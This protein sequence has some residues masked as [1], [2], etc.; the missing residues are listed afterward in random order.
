MHVTRTHR[1]LG[2]TTELERTVEADIRAELESHLDLVAEELIEQGYAPER[3]RE[4][5][6]ERFGDVER[7][8]R[9]CRKQKLGGWT[10]MQRLNLIAT[11]AL[12]AL[13]LVFGVRSLSLAS[14]V[15]DLVDRL[16]G[17]V[18]TLEEKLAPKEEPTSS[19]AKIYVDL[20]DRIELRDNYQPT[21]LNVLE[22]VERDGTVLL[23]ILGHV[24][25]AGMTREEVE[26]F[27]RE[28]YAP[29]FDVL[30]LYVK[31]HERE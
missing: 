8:V 12:L 25:V 30:D 23:P 7:I 2:S 29:Y 3:A 11:T 20:G 14:T 13:V 16:D 6:R 19:P 21:E 26:L 24:H 10:M 18:V 27:L 5:A 15:A 17:R 4:M 22:E 9:A 31:V 28:K 1:W